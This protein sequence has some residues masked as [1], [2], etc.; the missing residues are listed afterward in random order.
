MKQILITALTLFILPFLF[1]QKM[2]TLTFYS[3]AFQQNRT[4]YVQTPEFYKYQSDAVKLP[5]IYLLDGQ[6]EWFVNPLNNSIRYLQYT[7]EIPQ[8]LVVIV[9]LAD[10]NTESRFDC[11][12]KE[13][14]VLHKFVRGELDRQIQR[15]HPND[16]KLIIGHSFTAS[17]ALYSYLK[18]PLYYS[19]VIAHTPLNN[20]EDLIQEFEKNDQVDYDKISISIGGKAM[21]KDYYHRTEFD[22]L[23]IKYP[24]FFKSITIFEADQSAHNALP[25]VATPVLL[26][27]VFE[28]FTSRYIKIAAVD[29]E[30]KLISPP[31]SVVAEL[32]KIELASRLGNYHYVPE[33]PDINGLA[34]RYLSSD[35]SEYG[36][37]IYELGLS[38]F[39]KY[40]E[41]H[42]ALYELCLPSD[43]IKS[44]YHLKTAAELIETIETDL[45]ER[46]DLLLQI[47]EERQK[48][49]W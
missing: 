10:R 48:N 46:E 12:D 21:H 25:I 32:K 17:F 39:P 41:F 40:Y 31:E 11:S 1:G 23:K 2:D 20:F 22:R 43:K 5:V 35:L 36:L 3:E 34:S 44:E 4:V 7:H 37:A 8:A 24:D 9:P 27:K 49:G 38:Y 13:T 14:T 33:I 45:P 47:D 18:D 30:Y 16:F 6:H 19:A 28:N 42:L 15:Y 29:D 26:T